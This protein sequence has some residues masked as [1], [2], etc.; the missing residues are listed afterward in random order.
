MLFGERGSFLQHATGH[1]FKRKV[2]DAP[3]NADG[4]FPDGVKGALRKG[5][6]LTA[7]QAEIMVNKG[8]DFVCGEGQEMI[9]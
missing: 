6:L 7:D 9:F 4:I 1:G 2:G 8:L 5:R 3:V